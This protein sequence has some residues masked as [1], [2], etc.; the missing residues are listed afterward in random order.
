MYSPRTYATTRQGMK[1]TEPRG[2][3]YQLLWSWLRA[4]RETITLLSQFAKYQ[5]QWLVEQLSSNHLLQTL[6]P[7]LRSYIRMNV[8]LMTNP[9][10]EQEETTNSRQ[11][12]KDQNN[13]DGATSSSSKKERTSLPSQSIYSLFDGD[14]RLDVF[15]MRKLV[16]ERGT[17]PSERKITWKF[18]FGVYPEKSTTE[19]R[20]ELDQQMAA[21][22]HWMKQ[23]W[24]QRFPWA[25]TMRVHSDL[26]L[27]LAI[28][29]HDEQQRELDAAKPPTDI[30][31]EMRTFL[32]GSGVP[33]IDVTQC[34]C[35][36]LL[37]DA[38]H[39]N[40][41][42]G[43]PGRLLDKCE[44]LVNLLYL[45]DILIT[46]V[47][48]HQDI[49]YC[50]GMNDFASRFLETLDNETEAFWCFVGYMRRSA[51]RFT[52]MGVRRK[53]QICEEVLRHVDPELYSHI[54]SV[55]KEKLIFCLRW[56]LLLFQ[57]DLDHQDAVRVLEISA[58]ENE[59]MN[60]G[61]WIWRTRREGEEV[62][63]PFSSVDRDE[64]TF[65]VL[66]CIAVLIQNRKQLLQYQDVNDFFLFAQRLQGR[67]Q[68]NTLHGE[69]RT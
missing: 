1:A 18:L 63:A 57:K 15:R 68:L 59:K 65:E 23:S 56:L 28:Q 33:S 49:G 29:K 48:F 50:H 58:L 20:R 43:L 9:T 10:Q 32:V 60:F 21:Q 44:G 7:C 14:G 34:R 55:S 69:E 12:P 27:C 26:E 2:L 16:Y 25:A 4:I 37:G 62:P 6:C 31:N 53:T 61:A 41:Y 24:K 64:I 5:T 38:C 39:P 11:N 3:V 17:H 67:L 30:Y 40:A 8:Q 54:E 51:W 46:Y 22:Y 45:R 47:A 19:E 35:L 13:E 66:L 42:S 52:T 36:G